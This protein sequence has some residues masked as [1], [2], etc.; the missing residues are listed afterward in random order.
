MTW[1]EIPSAVAG[2][3]AV[4]GVLCNNRRLRACFAIW[5]L[6]NGMCLAV[7]ALAGLWAMAARDGIFMALAVEGWYK[8]GGQG[9]RR[10]PVKRK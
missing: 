3:L 5:L 6:S 8:W 1:L 4:V 2:V 7:H 9:E 10:C